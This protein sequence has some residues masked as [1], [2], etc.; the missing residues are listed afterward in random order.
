MPS[1]HG[2]YSIQSLPQAQREINANPKKK[3][4]SIREDSLKI[5]R[6]TLSSNGAPDI[7]SKYF[8]RLPTEEAHHKCHP[9]EGVM[10]LSHWVH[11]L[12][13]A[14][15]HELVSIGTVE[16]IEVQRLLKHHVKHYT[17]LCAENMP[18]PN[19][20]AYFPTL[21]DMPIQK[22]TSAVSSISRKCRKA[23]QELSPECH[24][25]FRPYKDPANS[26]QSG[27]WKVWKHFTMGA[28]RNLAKGTYGDVW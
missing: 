20:R 2:D 11:P 5:L 26:S 1:T 28:P 19:D 22:S 16:P 24:S 13:I 23:H 25:L 10:W 18:D 12:Q 7:A 4:H 21:D 3:I 9:T 14:K 6:K 15:I 17:M 8:V 27:N